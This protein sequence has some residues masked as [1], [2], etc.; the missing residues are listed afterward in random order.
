MRNVLY[1]VSGVISEPFERVLLSDVYYTHRLGA[2]G[3]LRVGILL[4]VTNQ[5]SLCRTIHGTGYVD[6]LRII[7]FQKLLIGFQGNVGQSGVP[8]THQTTVGCFID[9]GVID[10]A[11]TLSEEILILL[12]RRL[13]NRPLRGGGHLERLAVCSARGGG[14]CEGEAGERCGGDESLVE[15]FWG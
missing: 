12:K 14:D 6:T 9:G 7:T 4:D 8:F 3:L 2:N 1:M 13:G 10:T 15:H 11:V 5:S